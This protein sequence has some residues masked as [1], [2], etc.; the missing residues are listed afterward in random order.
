[1]KCAVSS[2]YMGDLETKKQIV[3]WGNM[4]VRCEHAFDEYSK[5]GKRQD[6][7]Q[8]GGWCESTSIGGKQTQPRR[9]VQAI[10]TLG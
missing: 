3:L 10:W 2:C 1:M 9:S 4:L 6:L 5:D 7:V 8:Q